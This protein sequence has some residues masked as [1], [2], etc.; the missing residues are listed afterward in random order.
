[1]FYTFPVVGNGISEPSTVVTSVF[2][3]GGPGVV[4]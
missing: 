4:S 3:H 1:M 2:S